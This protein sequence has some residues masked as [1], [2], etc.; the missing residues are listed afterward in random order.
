MWPSISANATRR[1]LHSDDLT[2]IRALYP[3]S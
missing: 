1:T 2:G 3:V